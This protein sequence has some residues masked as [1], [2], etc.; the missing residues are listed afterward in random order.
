LPQRTFLG[1]QG[2]GT[3]LIKL[4][5]GEE[6]QIK[7]IYNKDYEIVSVDP[8][9]LEVSTTKYKDG[10]CILPNKLYSINLSNGVVLK[11]TPD[12]KFLVY[13][14]IDEYEW[15][16]TQHIIPYQHKFTTDHQ[17]NMDMCI[18]AVSIEETEVELV[19][20]FTTVSENHSFIANGVVSHNCIPSRMT[21]N[22]LM[23]TV[24]GKA[25]C[26]NGTFGDA[27]PFSSSS[28]NDAAERI[29]NTLKEAGMKQQHSYDKTG[30]EQLYSGFTGEP[31]KAQVFIGPTYYQRLKHLVSE[32]LHARASGHVTTLTRQPLEGEKTRQLLYILVNL[33]FKID[34]NIWFLCRGIQMEI[35]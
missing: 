28:T 3:T 26:L 35:C 18:W 1:Y 14:T 11:C 33:Y 5:T 7:D 25:C 8:K 13:N 31:M 30:W 2:V 20:D 32:K 6:K 24:L 21:M 17:K 4:S 29:C 10:F 12:H 9:T 19:Y 27:T 16:E 23:E 15:V 34:L 22:H